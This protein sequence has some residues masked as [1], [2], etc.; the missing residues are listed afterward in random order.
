MKAPLKYPIYFVSVKQEVIKVNGRAEL[1]WF[2]KQVGV[3]YQSLWKLVNGVYRKLHQGIMIAN[4]WQI[5]NWGIVE[6]K[7]GFMKI[8]ERKQDEFEEERIL[9]GTYRSV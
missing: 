5:E 2:A 6:I 8:Q 9:A 7:Y 4:N 3:T 1:N